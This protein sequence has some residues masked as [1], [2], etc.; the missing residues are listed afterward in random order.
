MKKITIEF[1]SENSTEFKVDAA[2][3]THRELLVLARELPARGGGVGHTLLRDVP[4]I[5][6]EKSSR[7]APF[8]F[9]ATRSI[10]DWHLRLVGDEFYLAAQH[11]FFAIQNQAMMRAAQEQQANQIAIAKLQ[12]GGRGGNDFIRRMG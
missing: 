1:Q 6:I 4:T 2:G 3:A 7:G 8:S 12:Q 9:E 5:E 10:R 11:Q